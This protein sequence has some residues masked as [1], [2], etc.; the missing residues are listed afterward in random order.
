MKH[1]HEHILVDGTVIK[2]SHVHTK[3][4]AV[5]NRMARLIGHMESVKRMI[6]DG[7][8]CSEVLIQLSAVDAAVKSVSR[9]ILKDHLEHCIVDAVK[10][11]DEKSLDDLNKAIDQILK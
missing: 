8:D 4:K 10:N 2:H 1:E 5:L 3:T 9:V 11:G 7:R 6:E